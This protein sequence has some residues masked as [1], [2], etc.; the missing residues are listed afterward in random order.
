MSGKTPFPKYRI[1]FE[2]IDESP[3][4]CK[5]GMLRMIGTSE[6]RKELLKDY[7]LMMK[8]DKK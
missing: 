2:A 1:V 3:E 5:Q 4:A 7:A 6:I 8:E